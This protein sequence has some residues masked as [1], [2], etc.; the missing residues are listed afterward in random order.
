MSGMHFWAP[1]LLLM[2]QL[3]WL[4]VQA[5]QLAERTLDPNL[6]IPTTW[7]LTEPWPQDQHNLAEEPSYAPR[8]AEFPSQQEAS[9]LQTEAP[10]EVEISPTLQEDPAQ[11]LEVPQKEKTFVIKEEA[12]QVPPKKGSALLQG[13][14]ASAELSSGNEEG[15]TQPPE[16]PE[17]TLHHPEPVQAQQPTTPEI[18]VESVDLGLTITPRPM[19]EAEQ[20]A[21]LQ[22]TTESPEIPE[23][24][25]PHQESAQ[26]EQSPAPLITDQ[27]MD[28]GLTVTPRP[29][30]EAEQPAALQQ[31]TESP[32]IPEVTAPHQESAQAEQSPAPLITD[33]SMDLGLTVTPHP[34][35]EAEQPTT[36]QQTTAPPEHPEVRAPHRESAQAEQSPAPL[37]TDQSMDLGLTVTPHPMEEAE[38]PTTLQQTTA[39]PEHPEVTAP[40][41]E[42]AQAQQSPAP[43]ITDQSMDLGLTISSQSTKEAEHP[44]ALQQT[45]APPEHPEVTAPHRESAQVEQSPAPLITDQSMDLGLTISPQPT[46]EAEQPTTVQQTTAPPE[47]PEVTAPHRESAQAQQSPAPLI[48]DQS[49][50]LGLT[51]SPQPTKEAEQPTTIQQTTAPPEHPEVRAPHRESAQAEQLPAPLIT[52]QSMDLGLTIS[53]QSTKEAEQPTTV[54]QTTA[55]PEHPEVTAPHQESAQVEQSPA[56]LITDPSMDLGLT[57]S[58]Q[59]TKEAEHP[60]A[61]QQTTAPPEHPEVTAP[62]RESAQAQQSPAPL[63][64]DQSMDLGLTISPQSTKEAEHPAAL[65]QTTAPPEH[66][67]VTAPHRE[68]AQAQ[69]S[70]APLITDQS[71]D[72]GLTISPQST[73]EAE[74]PTTVQHTT[75]P[76]EHPEVTA[77]HRESAQVEQ[78]PAPL[79]TDQSM[80]LGLTISPQ[81]MEEAQQPTDLQ[82]TTAPPGHLEVTTPHRESA[83]AEQATAPQVTDQSVGS[84]LTITP[85]PFEKA[86][87][88]TTVQ[89][90]TVP[91][92]HP[93]VT[94]PH[95]GPAQ[96]QQSPS[97]QVT[98]QSVDLGFTITPQPTGEAEQPAALQQTTAP[99]EHPEVALSYLGSVQSRQPTLPGVMEG[100]KSLQPGPSERVPPMTEN[101]ATRSVC[102]LCSCRNETLSCVA[103]GPKQRLRSVPVLQP[104]TDNDTFTTL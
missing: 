17:V 56:P 93:E 61:L 49:M 63:I 71:M 91:P 69:Q 76:P 85:Q 21:T 12:I 27:S 53:P 19:E 45:T 100:T 54:Q 5:H 48:T 2:W 30:E 40:H 62:H 37:I 68:F 67:E 96:A 92:E 8:E 104:S 44:A 103:R 58:P 57:I 95:A 101:K 94:L 84:E 32:E 6:L 28:L 3:L 75:A 42:S 74:Q 43:L 14:F 11:Q 7:G 90:T 47:H 29:M 59:S 52:D 39:P 51:I 33:Q 35:E 4:L 66:P 60:A 15:P 83:E 78:S 81:P 26:A 77:P 65:Q 79:I 9:A 50:D 41:R 70:P 10:G 1:R 24:T 55:P 102:Q 86:E 20:P 16:I 82:Q 38:Q 89:Q 46:K 25:A 22:Q 80:D 73:K 18:A 97:S 99:P 98:V 36:V 87:Q 64:T 88:P 72:L 31:T 23:V 13:H 34:M